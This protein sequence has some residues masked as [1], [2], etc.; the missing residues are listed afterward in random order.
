MLLPF[1]PRS[2]KEVGRPL[3]FEMGD[4]LNGGECSYIP[5]L[6]CVLGGDGV[7]SSRYHTMIYSIVL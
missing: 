2:G 1:H 7:H 5:S 4:R 3:A 6:Q